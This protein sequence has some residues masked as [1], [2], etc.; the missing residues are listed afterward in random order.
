MDQFRQKE[1]PLM[2]AGYLGVRLRSAN[3][4]NGYNAWNVNPSGNV[5]NNNAVN[6][7]R[8]A[9]D[10]VIEVSGGNSLAIGRV[11]H[12]ITQGA[13]VHAAQDAANNL[14]GMRSVKKRKPLKTPHLFDD[15][16]G[17]EAINTSMWK[18]KRG[19]IWKDSVAHFVL[20][21]IDESL[22]LEAELKEGRYRERP[23]CHFIVPRP[24]RREILSI[25]FRDRVYQRSLNDN[26][27][28]PIM[29]RSFIPE[30][31]ACQK[32]K[33]T[34]YA[35]DDMLTGMLR[36]RFR[37]HGIDGWVLQCDIHG[38]Y[39]NMR[40]DVVEDM[41]QDKL[42]GDVYGRVISILHNQYPGDV[43]Y[44]PGSQMI[45]IA[46]I[47]VLDPIDHYIKET[48]RQ[49]YYLRYMDDSIIIG[50]DEASL[51]EVKERIRGKMQE[52]GFEFNDKK[53]RIYKIRYGITFLGF[54]FHITD[55]GRVYKTIDP[56]KVK[57]ERARLRHMV[58]SGKMTRDKVDE[59]YRDWKA[60]AMKG[61]SNHLLKRM[62]EFYTQLWRSING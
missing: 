35:R 17:F 1:V 21:G 58:K 47:S 12:E 3:R 20:N 32:Y 45:Q 30:N 25:S 52:I 18:C 6:A 51:L 49:R 46:G 9:P 36:R 22:K 11:P 27:L 31:C 7:N 60:H 59:C 23:S 4:G 39:P 26:K 61:K 8:C 16:I 34:D 10:R 55:S 44:N 15:E 33:G 57:E 48:L 50:D 24:K 42:D 28:Y 37:K 2:D 62:D 40:H 19:V 41:F 56:A 43:G 14:V 54:V 13:G 53:T 5:N 38:Y 29:T